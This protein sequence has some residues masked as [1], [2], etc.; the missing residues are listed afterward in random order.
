MELATQDFESLL[1]NS[2]LQFYETMKKQKDLLDAKHTV[3]SSLNKIIGIFLEGNETPEEKIYLCGAVLTGILTAIE[4][5]CKIY[6]KIIKESSVEEPGY[7]EA[8]FNLE[9]CKS[10]RETIEKGSY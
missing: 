8:Q 6:E 10:L 3:L 9:T 7:E 4:Q 2:T 5:K 1:L